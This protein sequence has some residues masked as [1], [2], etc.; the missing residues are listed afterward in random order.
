[1]KRSS[2]LKSK[3]NKS[4]KK[5]SKSK[6]VSSDLDDIKC[7][8]GSTMYISLDGKFIERCPERGQV[9]TKEWEIILT[10]FDQQSK[11]EYLKD[12]NQRL[13]ALFKKRYT[14]QKKIRKNFISRYRVGYGTEKYSNLQKVYRKLYLKTM[15]IN[16][17]VNSLKNSLNHIE[18]NSYIWK[19]GKLLSDTVSY[20]NKMRRKNDEKRIKMLQDI[21]IAKEEAK[22]LTIENIHPEDYGSLDISKMIHVDKNKARRI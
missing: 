11:K 19:K 13:E 17:K 9:R 12:I 4:L 7:S 10:K 3:P 8:F 1:M 5:K 15:T 20:P 21:E 2:R 14:I 22:K 16:N 18:H 6:I